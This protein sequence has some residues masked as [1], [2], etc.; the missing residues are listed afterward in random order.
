MNFLE[1]IKSVFSKYATFSGRARRS[2]FWYFFLL[3]FLLLLGL[4]YLS[5]IAPRY[6]YPCLF[7]SLIFLIP[8]LAVTAR[9]LHDIGKKGWIILPVVLL[10]S[11][12]IFFYYFYNYVS[13][14]LFYGQ[15]FDHNVS[16]FKDYAYLI[17]DP[18]YMNTLNGVYIGFLV[19]NL[20]L[21][22]VLFIWLFRD[23]EPEANKWGPVPKE[24]YVIPNYKTM[25]FGEAIKSVF[26]KYATFSGRA[27]RT[28]FWIFI[29][30][31]FLVT[32]A[33]SYIDRFLTRSGLPFPLII[34]KGKTIVGPIIY[35]R[36]YYVGLRFIF[37]LAI[38]IPCLSVTARRLHDVG[39]SGWYCLLLLPTIFYNI[40]GYHFYFGQNHH[41]VMN[42][43]TILNYVLIIIMLVW[44][45]RDSDPKENQYGPN[46][47][48]KS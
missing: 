16:K 38:I 18:H 34:L 29:L 48:F 37:K 17:N 11:L 47:K 39:K 35:I 28:E 6:F 30:F 5:W 36:N 14:D 40:L 7:L 23:S 25:G 4:G 8:E 3:Y 46:P 20:I 2:E 10:T 12:L 13:L 19:L 41:T 9:R 31:S 21:C 33:L 42:I 27:R 24:I 22:I 26:S 15:R 43:W 1:A 44:L 45:F 32:F